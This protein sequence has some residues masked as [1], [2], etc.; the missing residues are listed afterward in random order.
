[1]EREEGQ[2]NHSKKLE[3]QLEY[4]H[5]ADEL[6]TDPNVQLGRPRNGSAIVEN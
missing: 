4:G 3:A 5:E 6:R 1:M 2:E